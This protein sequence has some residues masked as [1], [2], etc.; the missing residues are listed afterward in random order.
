MTPRVD[1]ARELAGLHEAGG[2]ITASQSLV[3]RPGGLFRRTAFH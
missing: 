2:G 3:S 1:F